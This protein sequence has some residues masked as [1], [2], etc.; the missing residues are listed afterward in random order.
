MFMKT[1]QVQTMMSQRD[2]TGTSTFLNGLTGVTIT[3]V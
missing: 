3:T 1:V 2:A